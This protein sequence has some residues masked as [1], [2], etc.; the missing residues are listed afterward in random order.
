MR[1]KEEKAGPKGKIG[2]CEETRPNRPTMR[3]WAYQAHEAHVWSTC[4]K[5]IERIYSGCYA[6]Y[7]GQ[8]APLLETHLRSPR[9]QQCVLKPLFHFYTLSFF[10]LFVV[11]SSSSLLPPRPSFHL[12]PPFSLFPFLPRPALSQSLRLHKRPFFIDFFNLTPLL[13]SSL[14]A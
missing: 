11:P 14:L 7:D 6:M 10:T 2:H 8:T 9:G 13:T 3:P 5:H 1:E 12:V 4:M